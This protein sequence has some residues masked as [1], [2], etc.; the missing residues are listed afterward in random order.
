MC[1]CVCVCDCIVMFCIEFV[2]NGEIF[3]V[4]AAFVVLTCID[5]D[6][7]REIT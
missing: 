3:Y 5:I 1:V 6:Y 7:L 4:G 2:A